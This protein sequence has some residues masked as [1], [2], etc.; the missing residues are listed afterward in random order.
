[1]CFEPLVFAKV[2]RSFNCA[3]N[4]FLRALLK[5]YSFFDLDPPDGTP[6]RHVL[7]LALHIRRELDALGAPVFPKTSGSRGLHLYVPLPPRTPFEASLL[8]AQIVATIVVRKHPT[9]ATIE[10]SIHARGRRIYLDYLQNA[11][12]KTLA[13]AYSARAIISS[14]LR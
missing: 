9:L 14:P 3:A 12:G 10:R 1:M 7:D 6:F 13:S 8:Y 2:I 11:R 4:G 5:S